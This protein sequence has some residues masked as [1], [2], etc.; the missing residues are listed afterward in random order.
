MIRC[1]FNNVSI[2][3]FSDKTGDN[4]WANN[5]N[6]SFSKTLELD[7]Q[8]RS[9]S[10]FLILCKMYSEVN[11]LC[12]SLLVQKS[13]SAEDIRIE[14]GAFP[15]PFIEYSIIGVRLAEL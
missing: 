6:L 5:D 3:V 12:S 7:L 13:E 14:K 8:I 4:G 9:V 11:H 1:K 15:C 2:G 10:G